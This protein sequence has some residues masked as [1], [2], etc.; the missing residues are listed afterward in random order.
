M[1]K[2]LD[3]PKWPDISLDQAKGPK[4]ERGTSMATRNATSRRDFEEILRDGIE[5]D[6][7]IVEAVIADLVGETAR[8]EDADMDALVY[9]G[10][11]RVIVAMGVDDWR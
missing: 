6:A 8:Y 1:P 7:E 5:G 4:R 2:S 10:Q 9:E 11:T 3:T